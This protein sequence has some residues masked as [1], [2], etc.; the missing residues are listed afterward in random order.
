VSK[1]KKRGKRQVSFS[2]LGSLYLTHKQNG[3]VGFYVLRVKISTKW[4]RH[5]SEL[6][7]E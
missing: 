3:E 4:N 7:N 2:I 1:K 6:S 5:P